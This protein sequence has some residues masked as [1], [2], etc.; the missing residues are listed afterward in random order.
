MRLLLALTTTL[1]TINLSVSCLSSESAEIHHDIVAD[2]QALEI[3]ETN[4]IDKTDETVA[5]GTSGLDTYNERIPDGG[6]NAYYIYHE[7]VKTLSQSSD[8]IFV[9]RISE[10]VESILTVP[11]PETSSIGLQTNVYDGVVFTITELL[12]GDLPANTSEITILTFALV[13]DSQGSPIVRISDSPIEVVRPG[14]E[15]R[16]LSDGPEYLVFA[17]Q[18]EDAS[19][20]FY[21]SNFYYFNTPGSVVEVFDDG[22]L[23]IGVDKPLSSVKFTEDQNSKPVNSLLMTDVRGAV[24]VVSEDSGTLP[25]TDPGAS[26]PLAGLDGTGDD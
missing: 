19:S 4:E 14:I 22:I 13:K 18:E 9:G 5:I 17:V 12:V 10:Y 25:S 24:A 2:N 21:R 23:G 11:Q 20:P 6:Y 26:G 1:L 16:N 3:A 15:Q 7:N 8:A